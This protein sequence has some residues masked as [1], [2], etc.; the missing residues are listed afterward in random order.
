MYTVLTCTCT[1]NYMQLHVLVNTYTLLLKPVT[2]NKYCTSICT[3]C[4]EPS[5]QNKL[6][7]VITC[8]RFLCF[9]IT[10]ALCPTYLYSEVPEPVQSQSIGLNHS[11]CDGPHEVIRSHVD[12]THTIL[13]VCV[14]TCM[15]VI[16]GWMCLC[17]WVCVCMCGGCTTLM[18]TIANPNCRYCEYSIF[19]INIHILCLTTVTLKPHM[20]SAAIQTQSC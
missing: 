2:I 1:I 9:N 20:T 16:I 7:T 3:Q 13:C 19:R 8:T 4:E 10:T 14:H 11:R 12:S 5:T 15:C 17:V 6:S 18:K